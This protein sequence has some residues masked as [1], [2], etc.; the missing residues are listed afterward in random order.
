MNSSSN[1]SNSSMKYCTART[2]EKWNRI[3]QRRIAAAEQEIH[4]PL[5]ISQPQQVPP[6]P[7]LP[8]ASQM[9]VLP[10]MMRGSGRG[11][12]IA[13]SPGSGVS[14]G[15]AA[16]ANPL[17]KKKR[18]I[19]QG[20]GSLPG[21]SMGKGQ[22]QGQSMGH[23]L[24]QSMG[25]GQGEEQSADQQALDL[26]VSK[27]ALLMSSDP[28]L[29]PDGPASEAPES[30]RTGRFYA[31][32]T[33]V[34]GEREFSRM[35][36]QSTARG[37]LPA[38][39]LQEIDAGG[40]LGGVM[41]MIMRRPPAEEPLVSSRGHTRQPTP[42]MGIAI[43]R[44]GRL[45]HPPGSLEALERGRVL[46]QLRDKIEELSDS[47]KLLHL[48][49]RRR[50][51]SFT[52]YPGRPGNSLGDVERYV[53]HHY[54]RS[55]NSRKSCRCIMVINEAGARRLLRVTSGPQ[56]HDFVLDTGNFI[57]LSRTIRDCRNDAIMHQPWATGWNMITADQQALDQLVSKLA[58]L[59][60]SD[61]DVA[62]DGPT[63]EVPESIKTG[64]YYE[65]DTRVLPEPEFSQ[66]IAKNAARGSLP[67]SHLQEID[68]G[69]RLGGV[70]RM[71]MRRP[72]V[73]EPLVSSRGNT[74]RPS[75]G[76]RIPIGRAGRLFHLPGGLEGLE[77]GRVLDELRD[78]IEE[79][80]DSRK[81]LNLRS[82]RRGASVAL[83][84]GRQGNSLDDSERYVLHH[85]PHSD[86]SKKSARCLVA[87][88]EEGARRLL[89]VTSGQQR[90]D[91]VLH[92]GDFLWL[93]PTI[94]G[95]YNDTI[96]H[97]PLATGWNMILMLDYAMKE[98]SYQRQ[99]P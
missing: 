98:A 26:L 22:G 33:R 72:S 36:L 60:R 89:R 52:L 53:S 40:R 82:R 11:R 71:I 65:K 84:E 37:T 55:D 95:C 90:V 46:D 31:K 30:I 64:R 96:M 80:S 16:S 10:G 66:M 44:A 87:I 91:F 15:S 29:A 56:L 51:A 27:V 28:D 34:L 14:K 19:Q 61:P 86:N 88:N 43:G 18:Y 73:E 50:A 97:Q 41:R 35:I 67:A 17:P 48:R 78:K 74:R 47:R 13:S 49:S 79:L 85:Y 99:C 68:A 4:Q 58:L 7:I 83:Y 9:P 59:M 20:Q 3:E 5:S 75:P 21:M 6:E 54:L 38:S 8:P 63:S 25:Q 93:S 81:R 76:K 57:W 24:G 12:S 23:G 45:F 69:G 42:G 2:T 62:P 1:S 39:H 70:M 77:R 32:N 92:T 94:R